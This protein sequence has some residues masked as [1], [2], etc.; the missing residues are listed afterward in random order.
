M[1][2]LMAALKSQIPVDRIKTGHQ[3]VTVSRAGKEVLVHTRSESSKK[4]VFSGEHV[5][6]AL[7]PAL[8]AKIDFRPAMPEQVLSNW[9]KTPTWMAP[10]RN[11]SLYIKRTYSMHDNFQGMQEAVLGQWLRSTMYPSQIQVKRRF[12]FYW[13]TGKIEMDC[14]RSCSQKPLPGAGR[15]LIWAGC[16]RARS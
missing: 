15:T 10:M 5:F 4:A 14:Q 13:R 6:L 11:M 1:Q 2:A 8:A 3:V 7:P 16:G 9:R 12:W